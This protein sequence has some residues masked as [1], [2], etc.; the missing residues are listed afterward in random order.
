MRAKIVFLGKRGFELLTRLSPVLSAKLLFLLRTKQLP[1]LTH[2]TTFNE[3]CTWLKLYNYNQNDRVVQCADKYAVR[4]YVTNKGWGSVLNELYGVYDS[5]EDI[6]FDILPEQFVIKCTHG[7]GY[8]IICKDKKTLNF[9]EVSQKLN[10]WLKE[11]YGYATTELHYTKIR[12]KIIVEKYLCDKDD[13][14]PVDYKIY[15]F[16]GIPRAILVCTEREKKL[17][18]NYF[19]IKWNFKDYG[20]ESWKNTKKIPEPKNLKKML[21][22][23]SDLSKKFPFVRVDLYNDNGKIIFG[24]MTFT[25]AC[26]CAPY[27]SKEGNVELGELLEIENRN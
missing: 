20:K 19:D 27:Y 11:K 6:D 14:M 18:L 16:N 22:I 2:P 17:R 4:D 3:K 10:R 26:S 25:P 5:F 7:C 1:N 13:K 8:N 21:E 24:E 15:C 9:N 23:A 12:P